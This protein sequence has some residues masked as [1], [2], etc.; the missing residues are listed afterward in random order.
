[1]NSSNCFNSTSE[2]DDQHDVSEGTSISP[3]SQDI[4]QHQSIPI[5]APMDPKLSDITYL[6]SPPDPD[7]DPR[8]N[9]RK[10]MSSSEVDELL[11]SCP[12]KNNIPSNLVH[13]FKHQCIYEVRE[14]WQTDNLPTVLGTECHIPVTRIVNARPIP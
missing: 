10:D 11:H 14:L 6:D 2:T 1:M 9:P 3:Q 4:N 12:F 7:E 5:M 8:G 13:D